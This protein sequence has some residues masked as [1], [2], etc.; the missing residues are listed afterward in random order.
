VPIDAAVKRATNA[1]TKYLDSPLR[2]MSSQ[3]FSYFM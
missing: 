2:T 1:S 3:K